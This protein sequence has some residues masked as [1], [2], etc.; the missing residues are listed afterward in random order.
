MTE[1]SALAARSSGPVAPSTRLGFLKAAVTNFATVAAVAPSS[2]FLVRAMLRRV[3][4][5]SARV[6]VEF[7][8]GTGAVTREIIR[9]MRPDARLLAFEVHDGFV[10]H[11]RGVLVDPRLTVVHASAEAVVSHLDAHG[12]DAA[13]AILSALPFTMFPDELKHRILCCAFDA[14][15]PGGQWVAYQY[16]PFVLAPKVRGVFGDVRR[17]FCPLNVPPAFVMA[18]KKQVPSGQ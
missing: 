11:L 15:R 8:A 13:D 4:F 5:R 16:N 9:A 12:L 18:A 2:P 6:V 10:Q 1:R 3:D 17:S 7:G 14:L